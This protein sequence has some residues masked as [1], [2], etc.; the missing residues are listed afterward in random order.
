MR[1]GQKK[2]AFDLIFNEQ[3]DYENGNALVVKVG[4]YLLC[5]V[6]EVPS[7]VVGLTSVF[8]PAPFLVTGSCYICL[9]LTGTVH[10]LDN[11]CFTQIISTSLASCS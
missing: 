1:T 9:F 6:N 11:F 8:G 5:L 3:S 2:K 10:S 7:V 4:A